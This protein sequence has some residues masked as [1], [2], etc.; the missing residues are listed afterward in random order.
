MAVGVST[1]ELRELTD[2]DL[3]KPKIAV[4]NSSSELAICFSHLDGVAAVVK[5]AREGSPALQHVIHCLRQ[6]VAARQ[7]RS[8]FA[9]PCFEIFNQRLAQLLTHDLAFIG[10]SA[11]DVALNREQPIDAANS[12][13]CKRRDRRQCLAFGL[14]ACTGLDIS[15]REE[16]P[17]RMCPAGRLKDRARRARCFIQPIVSAVG[18]GLQDASPSRQVLLDMGTAPVS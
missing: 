14:A 9:H 16:R 2:E 4:V 5:E 11:V 1:G 15:E 13:E 3:L 7:F 8:L 17:A 6:V 18:V 10:A 12:F